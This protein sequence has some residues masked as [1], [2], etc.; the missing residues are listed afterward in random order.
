MTTEAVYLGLDTAT[1]WLSASLWSESRGTLA[2]S[3]EQV[4][5][6]HAQRIMGVLDALLAE[7]GLGKRQLAGI[8][9]GTGPG[10][11]T[12]L[13]VGLATAAGLGRGLGIPVGG[14]S[15]LA[16]AASL[17]LTDGTE[18][19]V[20]LDARR[21]NAY[22]GRFRRSGQ[23]IVTL[24]EPAKVLLTELQQQAGSLGLDV[25]AAAQPDAV[26]LARQARSGTAPVAS[27]L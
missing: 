24:M 14:G 4:E 23:H 7:A 3:A 10:S 21:G 6:A 1:G 8:G 25:L 27:Y 20:T 5:R 16:A 18:A 19:F 11:Y 22:A 26:W 9:V 15:T 12:G 17:L 2:C 13:R